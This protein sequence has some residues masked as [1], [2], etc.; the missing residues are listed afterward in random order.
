MTD[1]R[2]PP[3]GPTTATFNG[4]LYRVESVDHA[5]KEITLRPIKTSMLDDQAPDFDLNEAKRIVVYLNSDG[6]LNQVK[7]TLRPEGLSR[8]LACRVVHHQEAGS[9]VFVHYAV[10]GEV[11]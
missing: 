5:A 2:T 1:D 7:A 11:K 6:P 8:A 4:N 3:L 10:E 9:S